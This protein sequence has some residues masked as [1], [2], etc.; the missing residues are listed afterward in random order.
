M[1]AP[2]DIT[3]EIVASVGRGNRLVIQNQDSEIIL[4]GIT[5]LTYAAHP[6]EAMAKCH[7]IAIRILETL[8]LRF[9]VRTHL[10]GSV[11]IVDHQTGAEN[12]VSLPQP[13]WPKGKGHRQVPS[14]PPAGFAESIGQLSSSEAA[15]WHATRWHLSQAFSD[16]AEDPHSAAAKMWQ[17][18]E[19]FATGGKK[20]LDRVKQL[21]DSYLGIVP[22]QM[23]RLLALKLNSQAK[24]LRIGATEETAQLGW[25]LWNSTSVPLRKWLAR[26][27][28]DR[29]LMNFRNWARPKAPELLF[30]TDVGLLVLLSNR[31]RNPASARWMEH[32]LE[33][34]LGLLYGLRNKIVHSGERAFPTGMASYLATLGAEIIFALM[35][36]WKEQL[37]SKKMH[38]SIK[39]LPLP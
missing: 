18:L 2:V 29:S 26:V 25:Y 33:A 6:E 15:R 31:L 30:D 14:L 37:I 23:A 10:Y 11:K 39:A 22:E 7:R 32:R 27:L 34:D 36:Q 1:V 28:D 16:W 5:N 8:R 12:R 3:K 19:S 24:M 9:Y 21:G 38:G 17:G 35:S 4:T 13:F 20:G